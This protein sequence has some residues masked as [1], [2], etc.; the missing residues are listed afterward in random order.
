MESVPSPQ[1][2]VGGPQI[3]SNPTTNQTLL[4]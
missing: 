2:R 3:E 4:H 1:G